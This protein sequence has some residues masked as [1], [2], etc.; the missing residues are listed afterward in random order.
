MRELL[1]KQVPHLEDDRYMYPDMQKAE[2]LVRTGALT[3]AV[4]MRLPEVAVES[5]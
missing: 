2:E 4:G 1:R 3:A 5:H